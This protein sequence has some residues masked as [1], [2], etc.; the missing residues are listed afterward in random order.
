MLGSQCCSDLNMLEESTTVSKGLI[1]LTAE[2][3]FHRARAGTLSPDV[4]SVNLCVSFMEI[5]N[6]AIHDLFTDDPAANSKV[7]T[8]AWCCGEPNGF[9]LCLTLHV[10]TLRLHS[11]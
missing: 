4:A 7:R 5:Y 10:V 8:G 1:Y 11:I 2:D 6:E 3:L 9:D